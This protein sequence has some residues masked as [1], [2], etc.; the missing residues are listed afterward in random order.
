MIE[1]AADVPV[2]KTAEFARICELAYERFGLHLH[3]GKEKLV[4]ARLGKLLRAG[5]FRSFD[6]Y[7]QHVMS[8]RSGAALTAMIDCLTT[9]HTSFLREPEHFRVLTE[10]ILRESRGRDVFRVWSAACSTGEE[11]YSIAFSLLDALGDCRQPRIE[12]LATDISTRALDAA[13][14]AAYT[15]ERLAGLP[16][17]M[18]ARYLAAGPDGTLRVRREVTALVRF[19]RRNLMEPFPAGALFPVIFCRNVMIYFDRETRGGLVRRLTASLEPGGYLMVG[20][21]ESLIGTEHGLTYVQ[22]AVYR[23]PVSGQGRR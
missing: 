22:P 6:A 20:H 16:A 12:I 5:G 13:R 14:R 2:L 3:A 18:R 9:N 17:D 10:R 19:E 11:P 15:R 7:Y 1:A 4:S 8:D 23:R 21:A